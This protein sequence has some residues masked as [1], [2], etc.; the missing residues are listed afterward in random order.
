MPPIPSAP[1]R[2]GNVL[3]RPASHLLEVDGSPSRLEPRVMRL[4]VVLAQRPGEVLGREELLQSVWGEKFVEEEVLTQAVSVLRRALRDDRRRPRFIE[5]IPKG[6]YRLVLRPEALREDVVSASPSRPA[7]RLPRAAAVLLLVGGVGAV[8]GLRDPPSSA[9]GPLEVQPLTAWEGR[10]SQ[11]AVSPEG[12][13]VAFVRSGSPGDAGIYL[14]P[15]AGGPARRLVAGPG[16]A[17]SPAW[18]PNGRRMA[19]ARLGGERCALVIAEIASGRER[20][21]SDCSPGSAPHLAWMADGRSL[22]VAERDP[23]LARFRLVAVP[24][25]GGPRRALTTPP[26][27]LGD[28][29]PAVA[30]D[31]SLIAF[32]RTASL[33]ASDLW[34]QPAAGGAPRRLTAEGDPIAGIA[35]SRDGKTLLYAVDRGSGF[36][37]WRIGRG[38]GRATW[39]PLTGGEALR[40]AVARGTLVFERP[41][42]RS[43]VWRR[44]PAGPAEPLLSSTR[45]DEQPAV[46]PDGRW[47]AFVSDRSG[48]SEVW[49]ARRDGGGP[50]QLTALSAGRIAGVRWSPDGRRIALSARLAG[51][52]DLFVAD[53]AGPSTTS[54]APRAA[55][56]EAAPAW[57]A[58]GRSLYFLSDRDGRWG[59][60]RVDLA[61][62]STSLVAPLPA[63]ALWAAPDGEAL[64]F[65]RFDRAG[66]WR[67]PTGGESTGELVEARLSADDYA[68]W[69]LLGDRL[70]FTDRGG[71]GAP[72]IRSLDL[73]SDQEEV[74]GEVDFSRDDLGLAVAP[75]GEL[76]YALADRRESDLVWVQRWDI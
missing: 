9:A 15:L 60:W 73:R 62:G 32:S 67:L 21:V 10:E 5:T 24:L 29:F 42:F 59:I 56:N 11:P 26:P 47:I 65:S 76:F 50:R 57:S 25:D 58:D 61:E 22:V 12:G 7:R 46:S 37:L 14:Q 53:I 54:I 70:F 49:L 30:P 16:Y 75:D 13:R 23:A 69:G 51:Q 34:L 31:G 20:A 63:S 36:A 72:R 74:L 41:R 52:S 44:A 66:I 6:G 68:H 8:I 35:W 1:F 64:Y 45:W 3:V 2:L 28:R 4:L 19:F 38:G 71:R 55:S 43:Q 39:V 18:S 48:R 33:G 17:G 40:P 27:G